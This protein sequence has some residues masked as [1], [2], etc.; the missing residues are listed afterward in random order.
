MTRSEA[1]P[2]MARARMELV[3]NTPAGHV[4]REWIGRRNDPFGTRT[5]NAVEILHIV[6]YGFVALT[7][8]AVN[9]AQAVSRGHGT[10]CPALAWMGKRQKQQ[11]YELDK[12]LLRRR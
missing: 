1:R 7:V 4:W 8:V 2:G 6:E 12:E 3:K 10:H 9:G 11:E 5:A